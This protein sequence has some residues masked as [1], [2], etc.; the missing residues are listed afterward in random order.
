MGS[1]LATTSC[2]STRSRSRAICAS[3]VATALIWMNERFLQQ[4]FGRPP[5]GD[6][7]RATDALATIWLRTLYAS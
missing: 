6:A 3:A 7:Q 5:F 2:Y 4:Q 1:S